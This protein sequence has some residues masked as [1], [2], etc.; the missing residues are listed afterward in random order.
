MGYKLAIDFGTTNSVIARWNEA[1]ED[2]DVI[3]ISPISDTTVAERPPIVPSLSYV[4]DAK[5]GKITIWS[6]R[7]KMSATSAMKCTP[8]NTMYLASRFSV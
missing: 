6:G 8:R 2:A 7:L 3:G 5:S 4:D 1:K